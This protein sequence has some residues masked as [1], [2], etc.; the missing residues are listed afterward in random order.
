MLYG[1]SVGHA[2][3]VCDDAGLKWSFGRLY[4]MCP[5]RRTVMR[6]NGNLGIVRNHQLARTCR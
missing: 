1:L 4:Q 3:E 6:R 2:S 5:A